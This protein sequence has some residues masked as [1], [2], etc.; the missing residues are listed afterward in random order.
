ME[1]YEKAAQWLASRLTPVLASPRLAVICGTG[2][3]GLAS[4]VQ[5]D[6]KASF[7]YVDIPHFA[8]TSGKPYYILAFSWHRPDPSAS[9]PM[10]TTSIS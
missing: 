7:D 2:L 6:T 4:M 9:A 10:L 8:H 3:S 1:P 5:S